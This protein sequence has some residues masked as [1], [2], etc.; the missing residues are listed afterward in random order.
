MSPAATGDLSQNKTEDAKLN[1]VGDRR[2]NR[3]VCPAFPPI[4]V[5]NFDTR[6][7]H[8]NFED[9][10]PSDHAIKLQPSISKSACPIRITR[11]DPAS[12][13]DF[14]RSRVMLSSELPRAPQTVWRDLPQNLKPAKRPVRQNGDDIT[15]IVGYR[16]K[17]N[18]YRNSLPFFPT[19][20]RQAPSTSVVIVATSSL[21]ASTL[22]WNA[23]CS[24]PLSSNSTI[25]STPPAPSTTGTPT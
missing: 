2:S 18:A 22:F 1:S 12:S 19:C 9:G 13:S 8:T 17:K 25:R 14:T 15:N 5:D 11:K 4:E 10:F 7:K 20:C 3:K 24:S 6:D 21:T 23:A 16:E